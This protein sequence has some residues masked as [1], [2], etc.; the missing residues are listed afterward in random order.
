MPT[1]IFLS[2]FLAPIVSLIGAFVLL[3]A[4]RVLYIK[5]PNSGLT[6]VALG[7]LMFAPG[8]G[9]AFPDPTSAAQALAAQPMTHPWV[10]V[11]LWLAPLG[12]IT[13]AVALFNFA[14]HGPSNQRLERPSC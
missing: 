1:L 11:K 9:M 13:A 8:S 4:F 6:L 7:G 2:A 12:L 5:F 10:L 14:V 3:A